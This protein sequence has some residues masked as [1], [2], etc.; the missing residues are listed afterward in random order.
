MARTILIMA[1]PAASGRLT[2]DL[3]AVIANW[4]YLN[5]RSSG[6]ETGAVVKANAYGLG[7]D[8]VALALWQ[9]GARR[10][11]VAQSG[12]GMALRMLLP[13]AE[14][15]VLAPILPEGLA[16]IRANR[17]IV[18]L[19][20]PQDLQHWRNDK[21]GA[22]L[23]AALN[24]DTGMT[25]LGFGDSDIPGLWSAL[26]TTEQAAIVE[27]S[28]HLA[29]ADE[30]DHPANQAQLSRFQRA[31]S[32]LPKSMRLSLAN[33]SGIFLGSGFLQ[34][35][36]RPGMALYGLNPTPY[37]PNP[38]RTVVT[39]EARIIQTRM[40]QGSE[41]VGYGATA[42]LPA[43]A[44]VAT[45]AG[46]YA[47]GL[48]RSLSNTGEVFIAGQS[49]PIIGRVSMDLIA[50]DISAFSEAEVSAGAFAVIIG[51]EQTADDLAAAAGTI[52]YEVLTSIGQR[53]QRIYTGDCA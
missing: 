53:Y 35:T 10:F 16:S 39:L 4:R 22:L 5:N 6:G 25:R 1:D 2:I 11:Y 26:S 14:I 32:E 38:M 28:S 3:D 43:G 29:C 21:T 23:P 15:V 30:P 36:Q 27:V 37:Q 46:G 24:I 7:I 17:L 33:S 40:L 18:T 34:N 52:G 49:A 19:N 48:H 12:E 31:T 9:A 50:I 13:G 44:R 47:D 42:T 45:I 41:T 8:R 51:K 20:N